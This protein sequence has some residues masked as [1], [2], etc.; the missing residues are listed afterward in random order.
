M[1]FQ[2]SKVQARIEPNLKASA[3]AIFQ[4]LGITPTEAIRMF[5]KQVELQQGLPFLVKIPNDTTRAAIREAENVEALSSYGSVDE[6]LDEM[7]E[8]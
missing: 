3:E 4:A 7:S 5:Y 1:A 8:N 6:F 2:T